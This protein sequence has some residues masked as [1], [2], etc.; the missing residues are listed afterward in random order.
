MF[1]LFLAEPIIKLIDILPGMWIAF[2][3]NPIATFLSSNI[4]IPYI[5]PA[6]ICIFDSLV[7]NSHPGGASKWYNSFS[8]TNTRY[9]F[10]KSWRWRLVQAFDFTFDWFG[11]FNSSKPFPQTVKNIL[12]VRLDHIGDLI[13]SLPVFPILK[14]RFPNATITVLTG[15]EGEAI[16][17][18]NPFVDQLIV[19]RSNWFLRKKILNA[20]EFFEVLS[21]LRK[22]KFDVGY[23]LRGDL[24]NI[25]FMFLT[26]VR[27]RIGYGIAGGAGLLHR[28]GE[29]DERLHQAELNVKLVSGEVPARISLKPKI[30]LS[31]YE[32]K[33]AGEILNQSGIQKTDRI[34]AIHPEAGYVSK[35]WEEKNLKQL[36][37]LLLRDPSNKILIFGLSKAAKI[38]EA[39]F[40]P[41]PNPLPQGEGRVRGQVIN[42]VGK[43][44]LRQM[45][46]VIARAHLFIGND[47]GPSHIAQAL[48]IPA[49]VIA[50]GTNEYDRWGIWQQ[51]SKVLSHAVSCAPCHLMEC[52][53]EGH[54]CMSQISGE[55][56]F[57]EAKRLLNV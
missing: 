55:Q 39:F 19:F 43:I 14:E 9:P 35:E 11:T 23:D 5:R 20:I 53:V 30:Y 34:V 21:L 26:G 15:A 31:A 38:A 37:E 16:L 36:I 10:Q 17:K 41:H 4:K 47:S 48:G 50:S 3:F 51:P 22:A 46:S 7:S 44:S 2:I 12:V 52:N 1:I 6:Y 33:E 13:C 25:I 40:P 57:E 45:I 56:V 28:V 27:F 29:Y 18:E 24:R 49:I 8:V 42:L 32:Q 54:P